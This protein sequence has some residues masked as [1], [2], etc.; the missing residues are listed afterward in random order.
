[1]REIQEIA[2]DQHADCV[3]VAGDIFHHASPT[4][5]SERVV[6]EALV[7]SWTLQTPPLDV[8]LC[9]KGWCSKRWSD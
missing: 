6:L 3:L 2:D 8:R 9:L 5:M 4:A 7:L 1:L